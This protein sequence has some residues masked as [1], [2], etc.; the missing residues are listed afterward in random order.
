VETA[1]ETRT[2]I[3]WLRLLAT[4]AAWLAMAGLVGIVVLGAGVVLFAD[5]TETSGADD[6]EPT[7]AFGLLMLVLPVLAIVALRLAFRWVAR[8]SPSWWWCIAV[9]LAAAV[10]A[11]V[12]AAVVH[13]VAALVVLVATPPL[14]ARAIRPPRARAAD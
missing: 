8:L 2:P 3:G 12:G 13:A 10:L 11:F 4:S 9:T 7:G 14:A 1:T 6:S 5:D